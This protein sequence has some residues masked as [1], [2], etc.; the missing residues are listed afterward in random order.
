MAKTRSKKS[1]V[2]KTSSKEIVVDKDKGLVFKTEAELYDYFSGDIELLEKNFF[3][4]RTE[5]DINV[6]DFPSYEDCLE[7]LLEDPSEIWQDNDIV[8]GKKITNYIG[9]YEEDSEK[10]G[11]PEP[12]YYI[13]QVYVTNDIPCFVYLH[14]PTKKNELVD[15]FRKGEMIFERNAEEIPVGA[16]EGDALFEG[17]PLALGLYKAALTVRADS[18]ITEDEF[19]EYFDFREPCIEDPDEI[20]RSTDSWGHVLV[21]FIREFTDD[22]D[23][24]KDLYYVSITLE[25]TSAD[26]H[27]LLFSFPTSDKHL[28]ERYR[29]GENMHADEVTQES[30]H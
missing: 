27:I 30:S 14:F 1:K 13:A 23:P 18:D 29:H 9:E 5:T 7:S 4:I 6:D 17:E 19:P 16:N 24:T 15:Q 25:D 28:V 26:S 8:E 20:W 10:S 3:K 21:A 22:E 2:K 12:F 11:E